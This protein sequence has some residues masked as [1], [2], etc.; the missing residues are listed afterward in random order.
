MRTERT[1]F[2]EFTS[3]KVVLYQ[4]HLTAKLQQLYSYCKQQNSLL[5]NY[6]LLQ[7]REFGN[8]TN[9]TLREYKIVYKAVLLKLINACLME[10]VV[11]IKIIK[12]IVVLYSGYKF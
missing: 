2:V 8:H 10:R 4:F 5:T 7:T 9:L 11:V 3:F 12:V 1:L 6:L